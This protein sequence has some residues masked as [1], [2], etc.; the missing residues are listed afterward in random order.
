M[1][2]VVILITII[3]TIGLRHTDAFLICVVVSVS[4]VPLEPSSPRGTTSAAELCGALD[5]LE[6][7][8]VV[9]I[10]TELDRVFVEVGSL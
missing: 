1:I 4:D 3:I 8:W 7:A 6:V 5:A 2:A 9:P 10:P